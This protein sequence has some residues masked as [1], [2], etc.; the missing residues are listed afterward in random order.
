MCFTAR[1]HVNIVPF[2]LSTLTSAFGVIFVERSECINEQRVFGYIGI[3]KRI[4]GFH[5]K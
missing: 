4:R 5:R 1:F 3:K 2:T